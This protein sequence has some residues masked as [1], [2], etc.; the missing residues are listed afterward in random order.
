MK[1]YVREEEHRAEGWM[2][3]YSFS[4]KAEAETFVKEMETSHPKRHY[5]VEKGR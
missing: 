4:N 2:H 1:W 5:F 3:Y